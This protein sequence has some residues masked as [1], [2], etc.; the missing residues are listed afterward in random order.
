MKVSIITVTFNSADT[1]QN[2]IDSVS[3]QSYKNIEHIVV[4]GN[5][6]DNTLAIIQKNTSISTY[7][8]EPDNGLFDAMNKGLHLASGDIIG[9]LNSDD[10]YN[11]ENVISDVVN[12]LGRNE[13][14]YADL[15]YV[16]AHDTKLVRRYWKSG[17]Y[18][19]NSFKYGWMPPHPTLFLKREVYKKHGNFNIEFKSAAD[20]EL[21]LRFLFK[22]RI[23][24]VYLPKITVKMREGGVSNQSLKQRI[25]AN[26]EDREAWKING[27]KMPFLFPI[28]KPLLKIP[29]YFQKP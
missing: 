21:M 28:L 7:I 15:C 18:N 27:L 1:L 16:D 20:Y 14:L 3:T 4:D 12:T 26:K 8:S 13:A 5:S 29:Q 9:I 10:I 19:R 17:K 25:K 23:E 2:C 24:V 22:E 11:N 6:K